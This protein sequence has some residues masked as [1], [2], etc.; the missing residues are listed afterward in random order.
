[1][2]NKTAIDELLNVIQY[3]LDQLAY[4]HNDIDEE[5]MLYLQEI[6]DKYEK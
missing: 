5:L 6:L 3:T 2:E 1:M 4:Y